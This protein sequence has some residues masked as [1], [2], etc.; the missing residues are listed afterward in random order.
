MAQ[1]IANVDSSIIVGRVD[2]TKYGSVAQHFGIRGFPSILFI[3]AHKKVEFK[4]ER[5]REEILDFAARVSGPPVHYLDSCEQLE[6]LLASGER[7]VAFINI[8]PEANENFTSLAATWQQFDWFYR[9]MVSCRGVQPG[10][11][12]F[13]AKNI[14]VQYGKSNNRH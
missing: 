9:S 6:K 2:C 1:Q 5:T 7:R 11:Y 3:N 4:S 14:V 10:V 12:V 8:G 13:K